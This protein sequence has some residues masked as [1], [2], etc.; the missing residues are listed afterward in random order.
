MPQSRACMGLDRNQI[1]DLYRLV[2][3]LMRW[4]GPQQRENREAL[5]KIEV[6]PGYAREETK[7][8]LLTPPQAPLLK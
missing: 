5:K 6:P 3:R 4:P 1:V 7:P 2:D 8:K